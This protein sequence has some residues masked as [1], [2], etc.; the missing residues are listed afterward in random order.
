MGKKDLDINDVIKIVNYTRTTA[1]SI[2][3]EEKGWRLYHGTTAAHAV[4]RRIPFKVLY[5]LTG[6]TQQMAQKILLMLQNEADLHV[7]YPQS[8]WV[9]QA[10]RTR[11]NPPSKVPSVVQA[12]HRSAKAYT[13]KEYF[14]KYIKY[15]IETYRERLFNQ[16]PSD[17]I[18]PHIETP[19]GVNIKNPNPIRTFLTGEL[20]DEE[21][22]K[23]GVLLAEPGQGKTYMARR[24]AADISQTGYKTAL[25]ISSD[26]WQAMS[27]EDL[28]SLYKTV[29]NSLRSFGASISW[30]EGHE[31]DFLKVA[32][33]ADIFTVIFDG[34]D[35]YVIRNSGRVAAIQALQILQEL[36]QSTRTR[37]VITSRTSLWREIIPEDSSNEI[38]P[39]VFKVKPFNSNQAKNY[40]EKVLKVTPQVNTAANI[41]LE[42]ERKNQDFYGR[43]LVLKLIYDLVSNSTS[44][45]KPRINEAQ[46]GIIWLIE[47]IIEQ[48]CVRDMKR[49][50]LPLSSHEQLEVFSLDWGAFF[51]N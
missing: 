10:D 36:A 30:V 7:D 39:L 42:L 4:D 26:Q 45:Y 50:S 32:L 48:N 47:Q 13:I 3:R 37:I 5:L 1:I 51:E 9:T 33:K 18:D 17:Y 49:H 16:S 35:E 28:K 6:A 11:I 34:F 27:I 25:L 20:R 38:T 12:I 23:I 2:D 19:V 22:G 21:Q 44:G 43:G 8:L 14:E 24:L 29:A 31:E 15:E 46:N 40:F 41:F